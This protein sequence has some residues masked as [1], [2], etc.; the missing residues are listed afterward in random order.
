MLQGRFNLIKGNASYSELLRIS[1]VILKP[2]RSMITCKKSGH[3]STNK[4]SF[5]SGSCNECLAKQNN[6][7]ALS[8]VLETSLKH[9]KICYETLTKDTWEFYE[10]SLKH[11]WN[12]LVF[13]LETCLNTLEISLKHTWNFLKTPW[14]FFETPLKFS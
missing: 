2:I 14:N 10:K 6:H 12:L 11:P 13:L 5:C 9:L 4:P 8:I 1:N 3:I 7:E